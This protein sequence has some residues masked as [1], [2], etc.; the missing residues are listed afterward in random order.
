MINIEQ[1]GVIIRK[2]RT[3]N[4]WSQEALSEK[5]NCTR[6]TISSWE[7]GNGNFHNK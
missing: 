6:Q 1:V 5:M 7:K 3:Q 4:G 2:C